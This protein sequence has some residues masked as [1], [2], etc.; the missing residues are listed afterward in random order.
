MQ[1]RRLE[2]RLIDLPALAWR[3]LG[4]IALLVG[5]VL[6]SW[7]GEHGQEYSSHAGPATV[8]FAT[9]HQASQDSATNDQK[10]VF[11]EP[12]ASE[13]DR[14][15]RIKKRLLTVALAGGV[16]LLLLAFAH[17]YLR[18]ELTTR[19]FYS[20]RLQLASGIASLST[21]TAAYFLW[22]WIIN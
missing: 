6:A 1:I 20:G 13:T 12:D 21:L 16:L 3:S 14:E 22:R 7:G 15:R 2:R 19:G 4:V 10:A 11:A 5:M 17:G 8:T 18:L 9:T